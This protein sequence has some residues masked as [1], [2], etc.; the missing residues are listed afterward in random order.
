[1][2]GLDQRCA[3]AELWTILCSLSRPWCIRLL[4]NQLGVGQPNLSESSKLSERS[5]NHYL[6][7][8]L[9]SGRWPYQSSQEDIR[10]LLE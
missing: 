6:V 9:S 1:M 7:S 5:S 8:P 2:P 4:T 10:D 3:G